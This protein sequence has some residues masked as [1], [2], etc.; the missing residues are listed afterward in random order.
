M[1][2]PEVNEDLTGKVCICSIGRIFVVSRRKA[3]DFG[4]GQY[5]LC[6][7]GV[8]FDGKGTCASSNPVIA[9]ESVNEYHDTIEERFGG[10]MSYHG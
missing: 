7:V 2:M 6:W 1:R 9:Y 8:G 10:K 3:L 5:V 4:D